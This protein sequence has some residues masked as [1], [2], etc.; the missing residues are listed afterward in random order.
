MTT[1]F[2]SFIEQ[3]D[4]L[5]QREKEMIAKRKAA[6]MKKGSKVGQATRGKP[7]KA[8]EEKPEPKKSVGNTKDASDKHI[9]MQL[10]KAQ[11]VDGNMQITVSPNK[12]VKLKKG[13]IDSLLKIYDRLD[14]PEQKR[15]YR[16][17]LIK[18]LRKM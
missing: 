18:K 5:T 16:I 12:Q 10:R 3:L 9:V 1:S 17:D 15:K 2:K 7:K 14:K 4:E 11:D 13:Q 8:P 6:R